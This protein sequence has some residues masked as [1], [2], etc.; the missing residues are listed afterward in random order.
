MS[1]KRRAAA[2]GGG[3]ERPPAQY[4][5][6]AVLFSSTRTLQR[7]RTTIIEYVMVRSTCRYRL[8]KL[9]RLLETNAIRNKEE[10]VEALLTQ[11]F[12]CGR[13]ARKPTKEG[14]NK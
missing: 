2:E 12:R 8:Q 10:T 11:L 7:M 9:Q 13:A 14:G 1:A 4:G 3:N 5:T 6:T